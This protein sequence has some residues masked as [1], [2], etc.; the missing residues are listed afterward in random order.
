MEVHPTDPSKPQSYYEIK[1]V[2]PDEQVIDVS[3]VGWIGAD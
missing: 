1:C 3:N 2:G